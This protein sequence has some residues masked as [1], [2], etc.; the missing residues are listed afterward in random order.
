LINGQS[1]GVRS[2][3]GNSRRS[4]ASQA[5]WRVNNLPTEGHRDSCPR[6]CPRRQT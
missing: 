3:L 6:S 2:R 4:T 1:F 5:S